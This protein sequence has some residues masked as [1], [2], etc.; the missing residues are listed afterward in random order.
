MDSQD[1]PNE[2]MESPPEPQVE[3]K[4]EPSRANLF[5]KKLLRRATL[6]LG[7]FALGIVVTW[8]VQIRP[9]IEEVNALKAEMDLLEEEVG[10]LETDLAELEGIESE[11][12]GLQL[13]LDDTRVHLA[14]LD[15]LVDVSTA[16]LAIGDGNFD[17]AQAALAET[18]EKLSELAAGLEEDY[19]ETIDG[20]Q[21]RLAL[22]LEEINQDAFA[23]ESD[24][25]VLRN[26]ILALERS[27]FGE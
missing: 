9:R 1:Q 8:F 22:A 7:I 27:L 3:M 5:F 23:A 25:E 16:Q 18:D 15:I 24:L 4:K 2:S 20:M 17:T 13:Q 14:L 19:H 10:A 6:W 26:S 12:D 11:R 21:S